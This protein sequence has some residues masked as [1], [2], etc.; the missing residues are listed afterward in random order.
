M[1]APAVDVW[2]QGATHRQVELS[3]RGEQ[4]I[5]NHFLFHATAIGSSVC[6]DT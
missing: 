6:L 4:G 2:Y 3:T 5:T 1:Q